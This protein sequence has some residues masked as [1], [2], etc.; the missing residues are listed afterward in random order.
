MDR[1][2]WRATVPGVAE[3]GTHLPYPVIVLEDA[4]KCC[5]NFTKLA[6]IL[7]CY[8]LHS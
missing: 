3:S 5:F 4:Q 2:A 7:K 1:G 6:T 8:V